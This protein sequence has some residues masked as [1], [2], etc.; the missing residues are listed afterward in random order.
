MQPDANAPPP[1]RMLRTLALTQADHSQQNWADLGHLCWGSTAGSKHPQ[2]S[3][4][5]EGALLSAPLY[6]DVW[7]TTGAITPGQQG[8]VHW[9]SNG[10]WLFGTISC[11]QAATNETLAELTTRV[12][13]N[14]FETLARSNRSLVS[15]QDHPNMHLLRLW[16]YIPHIHEE[17]QGLERYR[18]FNSGRQQAFLQARQAAF[19]GAPVACALG[20]P[21]QGRFSVGFLAGRTPALA[22]ENPRQVSAY[23]YPAEY[24]PHS[25]AFS[26]AALLRVGLGQVA[27]LISGTASIVGHRSLHVGDVHAQTQETIANLQA[28]LD[29]AHQRTSARFHLA[30]A[31]CTV[32][33]R[34]REDLAKVRACFEQA[35]GASSHAAQSAVY[36]QADICRADLSLEIEAQI[37]ATGEILK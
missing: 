37:W 7:C 32:Y 16:N 8:S 15:A 9:C 11:D 14:I 36:V 13:Q 21:Q 25:P 4:C 2:A 10:H 27:L 31:D 18:C 1:L 6:G 19:E 17:E 28:V 3:L 24:G 33:V 29:A 30:Q 5:C 26:R 23:H 12:Y 35:V 34:Q 22:I 20:V